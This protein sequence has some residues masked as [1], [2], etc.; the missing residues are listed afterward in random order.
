MR[1]RV[2]IVGAGFSGLCIAIALRRVGYED[3]IILEKADELGGTW[4]DNIY[5]GCKCDVP[6][7]KYS[8]SFELKL[9]WQHRYARQPEIWAYLREIASRYQL[10]KHIRFG[11]D[12]VAA[13]FDNR[14]S[15]W[16][17]ATNGATYVADALVLAIGPLHRPLIPDLPGLES[18]NGVVFHSARW[19]HS[20]DLTNKRVAVIG[21]GAS[22]VQFVPEIAMRVAKL[23]VMQRTPPWIL[24]RHDKSYGAI[25][26]ILFH[27]VPGSARAY[28]ACLYWRAEVASLGFSRLTG[29]MRI[30]EI[31]ARRNLYRQI[32]DPI[33]QERLTPSYTLGCKRVLRSDDYYRTFALNNVELVTA[34][35]TAIRDDLVITED[36]DERNVDVII[37]ATGFHVL[38][39]YD[40]ID[41]I[42]ASG[43]SLKET[44]RKGM[45]AYLGICVSGFPNLFLMVGPNTGLGHNSM[46]FMIEA[47]ARWIAKLL[48]TFSSPVAV[49]ASAQRRFNDELQRRLSRTVWTV[50]GCK[51]WYLD[52]TGV[53]RALWPGSTITYWLRTRRVRRSHFVVPDL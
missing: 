44:W 30:P 15:G 50:G 40:S 9:N 38:D 14:N 5:P 37:F 34:S 35:I 2:I 1:H 41:L 32:R 17:I 24:P 16:L 13:E 26:R 6:S 39:T 31:A 42:G 49:R 20:C 52:K 7:H 3:F 25:S 46:I 43:Q 12:V 10:S 47:Q 8:Y 33:L 21:A 18:F 53:N 45:E 48:G 23:Y 27:R 28:R 36:G 4:R 11:V 22:A 29:L 19:D 51:S